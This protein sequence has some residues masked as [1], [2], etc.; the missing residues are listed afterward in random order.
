MHLSAAFGKPCIVV[1]GARE[2]VSF[3]RYRGH[4]YLATDGCLPCAVYDGCWKSK[5]SDCN[6][7]VNEVPR[8]MT[9]IKPSRVAEEVFLYYEG[10][11]LSF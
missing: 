7:K 2:P 11:M 6:N 8:C 4:Q 10:A 3:T 1:A 9:M 5:L